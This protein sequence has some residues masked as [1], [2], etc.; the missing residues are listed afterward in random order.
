VGPLGSLLLLTAAPA[1]Y[2]CLGSR[3]TRWIG[4]SPFVLGVGWMGVEL[5]L[6]RAGVSSGLWLGVQ[7]DVA[8]LHWIIGALGY[9]FAAFLVAYVAA[10]L[11]S[12][13]SGLR[14]AIPRPRTA[15]G[16]GNAGARLAPQTFCCF[17]LSL[18]PASQPRAP[19]TPFGP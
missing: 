12:V 10:L 19:P 1:V 3:L 4:Y 17:P 16:T 15:S 11:V 14:I 8:V 6:G 9:V 5:V 7:S 13:L 2:A 18:I